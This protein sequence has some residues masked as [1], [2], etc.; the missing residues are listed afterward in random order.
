MYSFS[1]FY[2]YFRIDETISYQS[3]EEENKTH[4]DYVLD[5][6]IAYPDVDEPLDILDVVTG[7]REPCKTYFLYKIYHTSEVRHNKTIKFYY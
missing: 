3:K 6:T 5:I 4:L 2:F 7:R 1:R